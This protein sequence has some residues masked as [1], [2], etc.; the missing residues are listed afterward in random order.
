M[1]IKNEKIAHEI[2]KAKREQRPPAF[3]A[4]ILRKLRRKRNDE[5]K[6]ERNSRGPDR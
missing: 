5:S 4:R 2:E 3:L 1:K 6:E